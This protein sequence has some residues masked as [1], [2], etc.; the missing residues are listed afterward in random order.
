MVVAY[1]VANR[2]GQQ[3]GYIHT[4]TAKRFQSVPSQAPEIIKINSQPILYKDDRRGYMNKAYPKAY[5]YPD[6]LNNPHYFA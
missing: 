1:P 4:D 5:Y 3:Q 6:V 2:F